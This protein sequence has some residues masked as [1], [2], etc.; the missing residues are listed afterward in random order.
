VIAASTGIDARRLVVG[1][2]GIAAALQ[3]VV[4]NHWRGFPS[5]NEM[6]RAYQAIAIVSRGTVAIDEEVS[7]FGAVEDLASSGG[8][9][10]P[11]KTPGMV[12]LLVPAAL[13]AHALTGGGEAELAWTLV[14][15]RWLASSL[16]FLLTVALLGH[17]LARISQRTSAFAAT[18]YALATPA[19]AGSLLLFSHSLTALLLLV[20]HV[21]LFERR[22]PYHALAAG[23]AIGWAVCVEPSALAPGLVQLALAMPRLRSS[24][25]LAAALGGALPVFGLALYN[26]LCF[27][28]PFALSYGHETYAVFATLNQR[29][30][31]G[32]RL[33]S[34]P[35]VVGMLASPARGALLW[36]PVI[37]VA[38]F[39]LSRFV[40]LERA[41]LVGAP[42][43]L[44]IGL[45]G[46]PNWHG[47]WF[48]GPRY[49]LPVLPLV[50]L[51]VGSGAERLL[52]LTAGRIALAVM[53]LWG[54][55]NV[56][57]SVL[58]FPFPPED[59]PV[60]AVTFALP[61]LRDGVLIPSWLPEPLAALVLAV[62]AGASAVLLMVAS[63][64]APSRAE[65]AMALA[66][67][68]VI[69]GTALIV[70]RPNSWQARIESAVVR[71]VYAG[72]PRRGALEALQPWCATL[73]Q[74]AQLQHWL[75]VRERT[76]PPATPLP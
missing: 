27:G 25:T 5:P 33:P 64:P 8:H 31:F 38:A 39:G 35:A 1:C 4:V 47:G 24:G 73:E 17:R 69:C 40:G 54:A 14:G 52:D 43:A 9:L 55:F 28:S 59:Y 41:A 45:S 2:L 58:T 65:R 56:W 15:G 66:G 51:L 3:L 18:A 48:P 44:L 42:L 72:S 30:I 16:P 20:A 7:R 53:V 60:P 50:F 74:R 76:H 63:V 26:Y 32:V 67:A 36:S 37:V 34:L 46:Y 21:L 71:D 19:L 29:G 61:L 11:N 62:L 13:A 68:A 6:V 57:L 22:G 23:F 12:P 10:Y 75:Q 70:P 49:L